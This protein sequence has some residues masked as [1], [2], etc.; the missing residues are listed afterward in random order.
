MTKT[1]HEAVQRTLV[2]LADAEVQQSRLQQV[3]AEFATLRG[4]RQ[5]VVQQLASLEQTLQ[6]CHFAMVERLE[7]QTVTERLERLGFSPAAHHALRQRLQEQQYVERQYIQLE[8]ARVHRTEERAALHNLEARKQ[9]VTTDLTTLEHEQR[10]YASELGALQ[11][12]TSRG[13]ADRGHRYG[14][15]GSV[16]VPRGWLWGVANRNMNTACNRRS[17]YNANSNSAIRQ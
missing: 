16:R 5:E 13:G 3:E 12:H 6:S 11:G 14:P 9:R 2:T 4:Q 1:A 10:Q 7:L 17:N 8:A 15:C